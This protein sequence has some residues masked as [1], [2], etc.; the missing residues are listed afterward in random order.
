MSKARYRYHTHMG[1]ALRFGKHDF[2][3]PLESNRLLRPQIGV[4]V[5]EDTHIARWLVVPEA[6]DV[7]TYLDRDTAYAAAMHR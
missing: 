1:A 5:T 4:W 6:G 3:P 2:V 7:E